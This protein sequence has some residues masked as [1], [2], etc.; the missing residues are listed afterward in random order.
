MALGPVEYFIVEK[1]FHD[2]YCGLTKTD[3]DGRVYKIIR[4]NDFLITGVFKLG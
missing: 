1:T 3:Q 4:L 2:A